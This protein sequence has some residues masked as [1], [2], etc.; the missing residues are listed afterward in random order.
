MAA[1]ADKRP[2]TCHPDDKPPR[3]CPRKYALEECRQAAVANLAA[4]WLKTQPGT[5]EWTHT[6][7]LLWTEIDKGVKHGK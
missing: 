3:P 4:R 6:G 2:C 7:W 1:V 5:A